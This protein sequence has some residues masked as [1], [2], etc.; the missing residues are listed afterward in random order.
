M[1]ADESD[2]FVK[3]SRTRYAGRTFDDAENDLR[4]DWS[5][6]GSRSSWD[7]VRDKV[8]SAWLKVERAMPGDADRDGR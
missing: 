8:R 3:T 5:S 2:E 1:S 7:N 4:N 6:R